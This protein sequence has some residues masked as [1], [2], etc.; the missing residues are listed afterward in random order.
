MADLVAGDSGQPYRE[1]LA[2]CR[3][4][5]HQFVHSLFRVHGGV[6]GLPWT[7]QGD[8]ECLKEWIGWFATLLAATRA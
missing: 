1:R 2:L 8:D 4:A 7:P 5:V 6:R 3:E